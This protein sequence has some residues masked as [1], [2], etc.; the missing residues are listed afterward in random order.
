MT[1]TGDAQASP[2]LAGDVVCI[3]GSGLKEPGLPGFLLFGPA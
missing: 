2:T 3:A 1:T